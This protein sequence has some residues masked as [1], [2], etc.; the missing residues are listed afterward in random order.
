M[1]KQQEIYKKYKYREMSNK[2]HKIYQEMKSEKE[3][4][5]YFKATE[6]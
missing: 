5:L 1:Q 4:G 6:N 3:A 2:D